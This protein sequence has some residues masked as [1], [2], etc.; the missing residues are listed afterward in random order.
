MG[1]LIRD[2]VKIGGTTVYVDSNLS[3]TSENPVEN[4]IV[5]SALNEKANT[6]SL[7]NVAT[8]GSYND[9]SN[10][11]TIDNTLSTESTNAVQ[12][13]IITN[14]LDE[15]YPIDYDVALSLAEWEALGDEK[16]YNH[17]NYYI[18]DA[19]TPTEKTTV[20]GWHVDPNESDPSS[21]IT[22]LKNAVGMT[23]AS[24]G[25]TNFNYGS[26]QNA[27]F[28]PKP[29][30]VKENGE[31][32]YYLNPDDYTKKKDDVTITSSPVDE[33]P[34]SF[35]SNDDGVINYHIYGT[36][37]GGGAETENLWD[38]SLE[39]FVRP[40]QSS[41]EYGF[42]ITAPGMYSIST[43]GVIEG[44]LY[45]RL[46]NS[47]DEL[48]DAANIVQ[49]WTKRTKTFTITSGDVLYLYDAI[50]T[51]DALTERQR[52]DNW[53]ITIISGSTIPTT[54]IPY[55]YQIPIINT[56][57]VTENLCWVSDENDLYYSIYNNYIIQDDK[58]VATGV[59]VLMGLAIKVEPSA[60]YQL[61]AS[62]N[63]NVMM[64][65]REYSSKPTQWEDSIFLRQVVNTSEHTAEYTAS[66]DVQWILFAFYTSSGV[67]TEISKLMFT[68][69]STPPDHY[70][71][72]RYETNYNLYIGN[73]KLSKEE[74]LDYAEQKVYK[75]T[76]NLWNGEIEQGTI[77]TAD[78]QPEDDNTRVRSDFTK[79]LSPGTYTVNAVGA[80][81]AILLVYDSSNEYKRTETI[82]TQWTSLPVSITISNDRKLRM[83][84]RKNNNTAIRPSDVSNVML[85]TGSTAEP[86]VSY[87]QPTNP[88][89]PFPT[90]N[91]YQG[92]NTLSS[93]ETLGKISIYAMS[94]IT[95]LNYNGNAMMEWPLIFW[96]YEPG[97]IDGEGNFYVSN[98][99]IDNTYNCWCN[100]NSKNNIIS[101]F[102][103]AIY[104]GG[105]YNGKLRSMSGYKLI[106]KTS[107]NYS[108]TSTYA[109][110]DKVLYNSNM[111]ICITAIETPEEFDSTKWQQIPINGGTTATQEINSA[112][113]NNTTSD[114]EWYIDVWADRML[115]NG[116]LI[117]MGKSL[118][119]QAIFGRG[120][121]TGV[122]TA[123]E[124]Y[125][126]G[127]LNDKGLFYGV[128]ANGNS[129][130]KVFGMENWWG[131][132]Y[133]RTAGLIGLANGNTAYKMTYG[134]ADGTTANGYN[135]TGDGYLINTVARP[136]SG[137]IKSCKF[138]NFG[139]LPLTTGG[140]SS[141]YYSDYW[142]TN[143]SALTV[144][145]VGGDSVNGMIDGISFFYLNYA[146]S[147]ALW[148]IAATLT[149]KPLIE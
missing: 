4:K 12:N 63:N 100:Y 33:L 34:L 46:Y 123:K 41:T 146:A 81:D 148:N 21:A 145:L 71:P 42:K 98:R 9:L 144:A 40:G 1:T 36:E 133:H 77:A 106:T 89:I 49:N 122:Q 79:V 88:P 25:A 5:T 137:Y 107:T 116:L 3:T 24:M 7:A 64:R 28:M 65:V 51:S 22:Y 135:V 115:I 48:L 118:N 138:G 31:V 55:G 2:G 18:Y 142:Y 38:G 8:T 69:G 108:N 32:D 72:H 109:I 84:F 124:A 13:K 76:E 26:W 129:G 54:Y 67:G 125:V 147:V 103:T 58:I 61:S 74:Y 60:T 27:F 29:C 149:L 35:N 136:S 70:I 50:S 39:T 30:M 85:N 131:C 75:R 119:S 93:T 110:N 47:N 53:K 105:I 87:L 16:Y 10:T 139:Y 59:N 82:T 44:Y 52:F 73:T 94:D 111:Y 104:N 15:K 126:T 91:T 113:A 6:S 86:Y 66:N 130:V 11:P 99:K 140:S 112:I 95:N 102:Y 132:V 23:P 120:L 14:S 143:N 90:I 92:E 57:G 141:T 134:I 56:S 17:K 20:Y 127:S 83:V 19:G 37:S 121:D 80:D 96:K 114:V 117:L 43:F 78:G 128:T 68:K 97:N 62:W 101:N 45:G